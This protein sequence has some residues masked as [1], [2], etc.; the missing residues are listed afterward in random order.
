MAKMAAYSAMT[1]Q[2]CLQAH[3]RPFLRQILRV[4][5]VSIAKKI[6]I[7]PFAPGFIFIQLSEPI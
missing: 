2:N 4:F 7:N 3:E 6:V 5:P 1:N